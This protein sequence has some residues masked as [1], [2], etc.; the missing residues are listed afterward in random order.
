MSI[1][2]MREDLL[3]EYPGDLWR[4]RVLS[5]PGYQVLK[6]Y[7]SIQERKAKGRKPKAPFAE[8]LSLLTERGRPLFK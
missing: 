6:I 2:Q 7:T 1:E 5:M 8:Q 3:R 4:Q